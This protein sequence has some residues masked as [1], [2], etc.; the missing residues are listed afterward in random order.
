MATKK[1]TKYAQNVTSQ[2]NPNAKVQ[3]EDWK[4]V[5]NAVGNTDTACYSH[6]TI[7]KT[8]SHYVEKTTV[9]KNGKQITKKEA[10]KW[11]DVYNHPWVLAS[12]DFNLDLPSDASVKKLRFIVCIKASSDITV[13]DPIAN[14]RIGT[15]L[16]AQR[17]DD[18]HF[19]IDYGSKYSTGWNDGCYLVVHQNKKLTSKYQEITYTLGEEDIKK[20]EYTIDNFNS[21]QMGLDLEFR[22]G[23]FNKVDKNGNG[24]ATVHIKWI[25]C[26][27]E[28]DIPNW[29]LSITNPVSEALNLTGTT[30]PTFNGTKN[31]PYQV[32][33]YNHFPLTVHCTN[34]S[35][36]KGSSQTINL[37]I[38]WGT[39]VVSATPSKGTYSDGVWTVP[40]KANADYTLDLILLTKIN[41]LSKLVATN[42]SKSA[43]YY[44]SSSF[45]EYDGYDDIEIFQQGNYP[46]VKRN[47]SC[48]YIYI[49]GQSLD[50]V[51]SVTVTPSTPVL[52][53]NFS[54]SSAFGNENMDISITSQTTNTAVLSVPDNGE[55]FEVTLLYCCH[56][57]A[58]GEQSIT[59]S[60]S[61]NP[62]T[63]TYTFT[64]IDSSPVHLSDL[65]RPD[66]ITINNHRIASDIETGATVIPCVVDT[67]DATMIMN[68]CR[69]NMGI[70]EDLDYIGC[71][72]LE[73]LHFN[74]KSTF[75]D[76]LLNST[77]KNKRYMGKKLATDEDITLNVRLHPQQVTTL[78]GLIEMDKPIPI[79]AN[80]KCFEGDALNHRGW[81]EVYAV[82]TEETNPHWY[83]CD[84]DV[85]Y[86]THNLNTRF[87]IDKGAKVSDYN[88][89]SL[90]SEAHSNGENLS[91]DES[92]FVT[93]TDGTFYYS[94]DE[95]YIYEYKDPSGNTITN[96]GSSTSYTYY[97]FNGISQT[98]TG[99]DDIVDYLENELYLDV[100]TPVL[101]Q[102]IKIRENVSIDDLKKN[103]FNIDNSQHIRITSNNP[104][105]HTSKVS[106]DWSSVLMTEERENHTSRIV[107]LIEKDSKRTAFEYEYDNIRID[108]EDIT[109]NVIYRVLK[110]D[111]LVKFNTSRPITFRYNPSD[112][113]TDSDVD[114]DDIL[115][116]VT[117]VG[118]ANYGSTIHLSINQGNLSIIDEG[119]NGKEIT[120]NNE[121][122]PDG[123]YYYQVEWINNNQDAETS[124]VQCVFDFNVQETILT[125]TYTDQFGKLII[126]PF[127]VA[128]KKVLFTRQAEEGVIYYYQDDGEEF[129]YLVEPYYQYM[130]GC[131]LVTSDGVSIFNLNYGYE[132]VYIQNGLVRLGFNRLNGYIYLGKWDNHSKQ[133]ITTHTLH[134]DKFDDINTN[135]ISDDK[136]EIQASDCV[137]TI[138]RGHPYIKIKHELEDIWIDTVFN[139]VWAEGVGDTANLDLPAY[140]N[141]FN[142]KNLLDE[143]VGGENGLK[144]SCITTTEVNR[145]KTT[146]E[147]SW[148]EIPSDIEV[149]DVKFTLAMSNLSEYTD[150]VDLDGTQCSFGTYS[151]ELE[152]D[153]T[154]TA[155]VDLFSYSPIQ[156][157]QQSSIRA[158]LVDV[159]GNGVKG[160]TVYFYEYY[161]PYDLDIVGTP[162]VIKVGDEI[163]IKARLKDVDGSL[164]IGE[165]VYFYVEE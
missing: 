59:V 29:K 7:K 73:H 150:E 46:P 156:K 19:S 24:S 110:G 91:D 102:T 72:P 4:K 138:Y 68:D 61:D 139:R 48:F 107:R 131:D 41:G 143:C 161:N 76:T 49:K 111:T 148:Y 32:V 130:N 64:V 136:I 81:A 27:V 164:I 5:S 157:N 146:A 120:I 151:W 96:I 78:Q 103:S 160:R 35:T 57:T 101:N 90:L 58:T 113:V 6:F 84:I 74:P 115:S 2:S 95:E 86:L 18:T 106:F 109:A 137:F 132:I 50:D 99:I 158:K 1:V 80:H 128:D 37:D 155:L 13:D 125:S 56:P 21:N 40:A 38:P 118:E 135:S 108:N 20:A 79:N 92:Y 152:T 55:T 25:K 52:Y 83:K 43:R 47:N 145:N 153:Y 140:W 69:I 3:R 60:T 89:P 31:S 159:D 54:L 85:K 154:P 100:V 14:F 142:D 98:L 33:A 114:V 87:K 65:I 53:P 133:Y 119:F 51:L 75:K 126:S 88:I 104:L 42:S 71:I 12:S 121:S 10:D 17:Y 165:T 147:L 22:D 70:W 8:P 123:E 11:K 77:Y 93:D 34:N 127:P 9:D 105:A 162:S 62:A 97:D 45:G 82:K 67:G 28:Y 117:G 15:K 112:V 36:V 141:L 134:L 39:R 44:Y 26:I 23:T 149:G 116:D 129:S 122:I 30:L 63:K 66:F 163:Q 94:E 124:D 144:S 16:F